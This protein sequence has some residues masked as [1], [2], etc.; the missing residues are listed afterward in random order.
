MMHQVKGVTQFDR[1][2]KLQPR[3]CE[4]YTIK[5]NIRE[6]A[7]EV[8]LWEELEYI[9]NIFHVSRL[10]WYILNPTHILARDL[11]IVRLH[12]TLHMSNAH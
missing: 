6:V 1:A 3:S 10:W 4:P 7:Y 5:R 8:E 12:P 11:G 9:C 2:I